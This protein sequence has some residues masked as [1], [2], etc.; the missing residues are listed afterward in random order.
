MAMM[1][2]QGTFGS[3][4][5]ISEGFRGFRYDLDR[6]F[7]RPAFE[8]VVHDL[9]GAEAFRG[10]QNSINLVKHVPQAHGRKLRGVH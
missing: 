3:S 1:L 10:R 8:I 4:A 7:D 5:R 6:P 2:A 9:F